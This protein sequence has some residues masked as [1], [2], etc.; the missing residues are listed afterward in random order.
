MCTC[1][2][3]TISLAEVLN[4]V[5]VSLIAQGHSLLAASVDK[6]SIELICCEPR[7]RPAGIP[8]VDVRPDSLTIRTVADAII[9]YWVNI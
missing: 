8:S 7:C 4:Y 3:N 9:S 6:K 5:G 2:R 1:R